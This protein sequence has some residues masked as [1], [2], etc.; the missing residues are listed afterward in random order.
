MALI[1]AVQKVSGLR[2][3]PSAKLH[4]GVRFL[5]FAPA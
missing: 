1:V 5:T 2:A 4:S 3:R